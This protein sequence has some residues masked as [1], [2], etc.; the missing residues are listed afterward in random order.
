M[1][2]VTSREMAV[3]HGMSRSFKDVA[4]RLELTR[5]AIGLSKSELCRRLEINGSAWSN[6]INTNYDRRISLEVAFKLKDEFG[7][8]LEWIYDGDAKLLPQVLGDRIR[9]LRKKAAA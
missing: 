7:V 6:F 3:N 9:D 2:L 1:E 8:T 4:T 5:K